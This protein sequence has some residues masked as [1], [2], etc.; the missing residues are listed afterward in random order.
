MEEEEGG[1]NCK[2]EQVESGTRVEEG[3]DTAETENGRKPE[4]EK[5]EE[6]KEE[7]E[8]DCNGKDEIHEKEGNFAE[9]IEIEQE[10]SHNIKIQINQ[11]LGSKVKV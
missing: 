2:R 6:E 8:E 9:E 10:N 1:C 5:E 3:E 7:E 4:G 11:Y